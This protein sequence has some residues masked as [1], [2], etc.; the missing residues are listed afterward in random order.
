MNLKPASYDR[1]FGEEKA[2]AKVAAIARGDTIWGGAKA[3][4]MTAKG[5][6]LERL[7]YVVS[8]VYSRSTGKH[9]RE[10]EAWECPECGQAHLG[11]EKAFACCRPEE[12]EA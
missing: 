3:L 7:S 8:D 11:Q 12:V 4:V 1:L 2:I 9:S 6:R 5:K 10:F